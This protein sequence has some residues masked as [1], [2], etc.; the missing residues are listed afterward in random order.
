VTL[1]S[2]V[3]GALRLRLPGLPG[4]DQE[5]H[6]TW[7][8]LFFDLVFV[9][10]LSAVTGRLGTGAAPTAAEIGIALALF[11]LVLWAWIG[12]SFYDTRFDPDDPPHRLLVFVA[13]AGAG[14]IA[15]GTH[16]VPG[17]LLLPVGYLVV[18]GALLAM[19]LR[20]LAAPGQGRQIATVY[21]TGFGAGWLLWLG[22]LALAAAGRPVVWAT[23]LVVE[24]LTPWLGRRWLARHPVDASHLPE[25]I[26]QFIIILLGSTLTNLRDAVPTSHPPGRAV[27][28][29]AVAFVV[30]I[31]VW[32]VYTTFLT[33]RLAIHRL[34][35]GQGYSFLHAPAGAA[36]LFLGW[37]IGEVVREIA[38][39]SHRLPASLRLVL[40]GSVVVWLLSGLALHW[41]AVGSVS[42]RRIGIVV[43]GVLP[44]AVVASVVTDPGLTLVLMA[45][46]LV[47]Y[48]AAVSRHIRRR[49]RTAGPSEPGAVEPGR[50]QSSGSS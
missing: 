37:S 31:C 21:L 26:G 1:L 29:A 41:F 9:L 28:A 8:E 3:A 43:L 45:A 2:R 13:T 46:V 50:P 10:A 49:V 15:L 14:A 25:R 11:A 33:S 7:L 6:A 42:R 4:Q 47:G 22:S 27:A 48:A 38:H 17:S 5:R 23:A 39:G 34:R 24:M 12:Q 36:I 32:W 19:Y 44:T 18:R 20:V 40:G 16:E 35:S 30:P